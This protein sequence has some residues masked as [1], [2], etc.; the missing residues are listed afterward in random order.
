MFNHKFTTMKR[1]YLLLAIAAIGVAACHNENPQEVIPPVEEKEV[2]ARLKFMDDVCALGIEVDDDLFLWHLE[3]KVFYY[4]N[5]SE[6]TASR[7]SYGDIGMYG[8]KDGEMIWNLPSGNWDRNNRTLIM[9]DN[10]Y[11]RTHGIWGYFPNENLEENRFPEYEYDEKGYR[12]RYWRY[13]AE[14]NM[15]YTN[16][17]GL[18]RVD[19]SRAEVLYV[20]SRI[21][22]LKGQIM[23]EPSTKNADWGYFYVD[24]KKYD[25]EAYMSE[26]DK[27]FTYYP[28]YIEGDWE[29]IEMDKSVLT[30]DAEGGTESSVA[31]NYDCLWLCYAGEYVANDNGTIQKSR[32][33]DPTEDGLII[34]AS[35]FRVEIPEGRENELVMTVKKNNTQMPREGFVEFQVA[36][37][38]A[39]S[40]IEIRQM[41]E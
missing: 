14:T 33:Y 13:D 18:E 31:L 15:L 1:L 19:D 37:G 23:N 38:D 32:Y 6:G 29:L 39:F 2:D 8:S 40:F 9:M 17:W 36:G 5:D 3:N 27:D 21:A 20:D 35:W 7:C 11:C 28:E 34:E 24:F 25:R 41:A 22:I 4:G 26:Y 30:F 10:G 16:M 12:N